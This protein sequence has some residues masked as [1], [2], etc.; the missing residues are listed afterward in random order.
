MTINGQSSF[1]FSY[2]GIANK[3]T[4]SN[5]GNYAAPALDSIAEVKVQSS[6]F[7]AEYGRSS[8]A[9]ITVVTKSGT[10]NFR[11]TAAYY[12]RN[13]NVQLEHV[14]S[15]PQ[16]RRA[17]GIVNGVRIRTAAR[18]RTGSTTRR[19]RSAARSAAGHRVQREP[20]KLFFFWSQDL[21][22]RND[23]GDSL[24]QHDADGARARRATSRR[25]SNTNG[26]RIWI[27]DPQLAAQGLACNPTAGGAGCF[28][29]NIIPANRINPIGQQMLSL[30]PLPNATDPTGSR[31]FNY[32][33]PDA[34]L[35]SRG[36]TRCCASTTTSRQ[37]TTFYTPRAVRHTKSDA[38]RVRRP[39]GAGTRRRRQR[40]WPQM[41]NSYDIN[42]VSSVN[43]LLHTFSPTTVL[44]VTV[45]RELVAAVRV[46][47]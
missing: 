25:R 34:D 18:R 8:G 28:A 17:P 35:R 13:E 20:D 37:S 12:K 7:Q 33:Y 3:D 36:T 9:T 5:S 23:P 22:P 4:G 45:G 14:G 26:A 31:Q 24:Q 29:N 16:L 6:N 1:N 15:P 42:T 43:T 40:N 30:F 21:L 39:A 19:G 11:G 10:R 41:H 44:E 2:D 32:Q 47:R 46:V 27:K 38:T